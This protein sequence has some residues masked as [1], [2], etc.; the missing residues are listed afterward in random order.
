MAKK[1]RATKKRSTKKRKTTRKKVKKKS[2][3]KTK[4]KKKKA[5]KKKKTKKKAKKKTKAK[6]KVKKKAKKKTKKKAKKKKTKKKTKK[7]TKKE[8]KKRK[9]SAAFM[10]P[11]QPDA[12]LAEIVGSDPLPRTQV[13]KKLWIYIKKHELQDKND[14]R[15]IIA[16]E[17]MKPVFGGQASV[18]MLQM[19]KLVFMHL[20]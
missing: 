18:N 15:V 13:I 10:A 11:V 16:D 17:K 2:T 14:G 3:K 5:T 8:G 1:K 20:K 19:T 4:K 9:P 6:K 12:V 7:E